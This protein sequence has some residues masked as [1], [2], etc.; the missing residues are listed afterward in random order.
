MGF[1]LESQRTRPVTV[2]VWPVFLL[3]TWLT[4]LFIYI[5]FQGAFPVFLPCVRAPVH[6]ISAVTFIPS[7]IVTS[8]SLLSLGKRHNG[9]S[10]ALCPTC[11]CMYLSYWDQVILVTVW[12][13]PFFLPCALHALSHLSCWSLWLEGL[14]PLVSTLT[15]CQHLFLAVARMGMTPLSSCWA[16]LFQIGLRWKGRLLIIGKYGNGRPR[17]SPCPSVPALKETS[18]SQP[19]FIKAKFLLPT[20]T[21]RPIEL[22]KS[23]PF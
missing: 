17:L 21:R 4:A 18:L 10:Y 2:C 20:P 19:A 12:T 11:A 5:S 8:P 14:H 15:H 9:I 22:G 1:P 3:V 6:P 16:L 23:G 7:V 13:H